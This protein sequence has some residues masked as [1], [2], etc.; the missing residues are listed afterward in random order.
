[1]SAQLVALLNVAKTEKHGHPIY[2]CMPQTK[3]HCKGIVTASKIKLMLLEAFALHCVEWVNPSNKSFSICQISYP[4]PNP[5]FNNF[6]FQLKILEFTKCTILFMVREMGNTVIIFIPNNMFKAWRRGRI[7]VYA[8][9]WHVQYTHTHTHTHTCIQ[10]LT[11][12][13]YVC[14]P[15]RARARVCVCARAHAYVCHVRACMSV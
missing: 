6:C 9:V 14:V 2:W 13:V 4:G 10:C 3:F 8:I 12:C 1:M 5:P 7:R 15:V 11:D